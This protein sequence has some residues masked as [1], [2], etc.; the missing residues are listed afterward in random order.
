MNDDNKKNSSSQLFEFTKDSYLDRT[1]R[2]IYALTYLVGFIVLYEIGTFLI[3]TDVLSS[4]LGNTQVR[5]VSFA[6]IQNLLMDYLNFPARM[7]WIATPLVV[8]VILLALQI[9]SKTQW[10][11]RAYDFVPMT[12]ECILLAV[13]L[14]VLCLTIN[15][16]VSQQAAQL[17]A[18]ETTNTFLQ[19]LVTSIGAGIY[20]GL[21][22]RLILI[23]LL[24]MLFQD[25]L[26]VTRKSSIVLSV[27]IS[28]VLFSVHHH[29]YFIN[30]S[31]VHGDP[32]VLSEFTFRVL[33]GIY[34]AAIF[35]IRGF[36]IAAG[37]HIF[38]DIIVALM[39]WHSASP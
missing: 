24:M 9:T 25:F 16:S 5:V 39:L 27:L 36:A 2:P 3:S 12:I 8:M 29:V 10:K 21:V 32:F 26:M 7:T 15:R 34:F 37:T 18:S 38:Y 33:A 13:P 6:W 19:N 11:V 28:A 4:S 22:F 17:L 14:I 23:S 1:S 35:A 30:G 31:F 20:E